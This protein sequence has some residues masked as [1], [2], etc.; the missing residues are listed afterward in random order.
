MAGGPP[1][2]TTTLGGLSRKARPLICKATENSRSD[3]PSC[4]RF[5][6]NNLTIEVHCGGRWFGSDSLRLASVCSTDSYT[7]LRSTFVLG[8]YA[9]PCG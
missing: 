5:S 1:M 9:A 4:H 8:F 2:T 7:R 3:T 6:N